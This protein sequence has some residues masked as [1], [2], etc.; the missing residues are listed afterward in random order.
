[1]ECLIL[2][3]LGVLH[4]LG[5]PARGDDLLRVRAHRGRVGEALVRVERADGEEARDARGGDALG[6]RGARL[7]GPAV[8]SGG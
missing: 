7:G 4:K 8:V 3:A 6:R 1:M 5:R 2:T